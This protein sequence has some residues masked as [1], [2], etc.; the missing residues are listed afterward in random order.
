M[1][2]HASMMLSPHLI[3]EGRI[4]TVTVS[5]SLDII[6]A[7][8][9]AI[10]DKLEQGTQYQKVMVHLSHFTA[11]LATM[12]AAYEYLATMSMIAQS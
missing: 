11:R 1:G 12:R 8:S 9:T 5:K 2:H 3:E 7:H 6:S 4:W 10:E